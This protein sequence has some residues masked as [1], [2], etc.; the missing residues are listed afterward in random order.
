MPCTRGSGTGC[1]NDIQNDKGV[2][3]FRGVTYGLCAT[4]ERDFDTSLKR[5][6]DS[7][8]DWGADARKLFI[9]TSAASIFDACMWALVQESARRNGNVL[10]RRWRM[11]HQAFHLSKELAY[12]ESKCWFGEQKKIFSGLLSSEEFLNAM[13]QG[14]MVKD[15][16]P[17]PNH[18]EFSHRLQWHML[19]RVMTAD[20]TQAKTGDWD[21]TPL[22]LYCWTGTSQYWGA[23]LEGNPPTAGGPGS[24]QWVDE[25]LRKEPL[26]QT[27]LGSAIEQRRNKRLELLELIAQKAEAYASERNILRNL[28]LH[29]DG[30]YKTDGRRYMLKGRADAEARS[31]PKLVV[32]DMLQIAETV[33][34]WKKTGQ[35][36]IRVHDPNDH[37]HNVALKVWNE[38]AKALSPKR[39]AHY[40]FQ[41]L[42]N[43]KQSMGILLGN[44][45]QDTP[46]EERITSSRQRLG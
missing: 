25:R 33:Y 35:L 37:P 32:L 27:C 41:Q 39:G 26:L 15:P 5:F 23:A 6:A 8:G 18:G 44:N 12:Y 4:H 43:G 17:G 29:H 28:I 40:N 24:P 11:E 30:S 14:F 13:T 38:E 7:A 16:G 19:M 1:S 31:N 20:F 34:A 22:E 3:T 2:V 45:A 42:E 21:H 10:T 46:I 36:G 9:V